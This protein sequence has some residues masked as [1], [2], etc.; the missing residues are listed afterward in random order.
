M[1][2]AAVGVLALGE[3]TAWICAL[4]T[5]AQFKLF[6][7]VA[8]IGFDNAAMI[9]FIS[10]MAVVCVLV[11]V[12]G[13]KK[14]MRKV[15]GSM[16]TSAPA[17]AALQ[18][19]YNVFYGT[20]VLVFVLAAVLVGTLG[21]NLMFFIPLLCVSGAMILYHLTSLKLWMP[22]A[23]GLVLLHAFSFLYALAMALTIGALGAV[24]MLAFMD[25]MLL[26]PLADIYLMNMK[27]K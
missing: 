20:A 27:K 12:L 6:G 4:C 9:A 16:R 7:V 23:I 14:A 3:L 2:G 26:V 1:L 22:L 24:A 17:N 10:V 21:E 18:H 19:A 13:R 15:S 8:G 25:V 11:Y 5:G